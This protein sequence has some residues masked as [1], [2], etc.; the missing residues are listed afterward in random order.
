MRKKGMFHTYQKRIKCLCPQGHVGLRQIA[1]DPHGFFRSH[2]IGNGLFNFPQGALSFPL[3]ASLRRH[4]LWVRLERKLTQS[5]GV[6]LM[7]CFSINVPLIR[8]IHQSQP[9]TFNKPQ[10]P[11]LL[12]EMCQYREKCEAYDKVSVLDPCNDLSLIMG[13]IHTMPCPVSQINKA[14]PSRQ[15]IYFWLAIHYIY[16]FKQSLWKQ[17]SSGFFGFFS[18]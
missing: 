11:D 8:F 10:H 4:P 2:S 13:D 3:S 7:N 1:T 14:E 12:R 15:S 9:M 18:T 5:R 17:M 6:F 16:I